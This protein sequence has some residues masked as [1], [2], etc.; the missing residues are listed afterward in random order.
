MQKGR[1]YWS[2][3]KKDTDFD[4]LPKEKQIEI[5]VNNGVYVRVNVASSAS[6]NIKN[7]VLYLPDIREEQEPNQEL[8]SEFYEYIL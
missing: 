5:L 2:C 1:R 4:S 6:L 7:G 8:K 3:L